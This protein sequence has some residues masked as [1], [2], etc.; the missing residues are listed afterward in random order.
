M[1]YVPRLDPA[2][3]AKSVS[4]FL[5]LKADIYTNLYFKNG[6]VRTIDLPNMEKLLIDGICRKI[7]IDDKFITDKH[8]RKIQ[9]DK[10][11]ILCEMGFVD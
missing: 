10:E 11:F 1:E 2:K 7:G 4:G 8:T 6:S 3:G 5:Y 9:S